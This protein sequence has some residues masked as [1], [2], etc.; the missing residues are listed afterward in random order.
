MQLRFPRPIVDIPYRLP[1][2]AHLQLA[3]R[4]LTWHEESESIDAL[5]SGPEELRSSRALDQL[6]VHALLVNGKRA[7]SNKTELRGLQ[8][9]EATDLGMAVLGGLN[10][11][12]PSYTRHDSFAWHIAFSQGF[13]HPSNGGEVHWIGQNPRAYFGMPIAKLTDGQRMVMIA[14]VEIYRAARKR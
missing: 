8:E 9:Q 5:R 13:Q 2:A 3:V 1:C 14:A 6:I 12:S 10:I 11:I 7:F 4:A